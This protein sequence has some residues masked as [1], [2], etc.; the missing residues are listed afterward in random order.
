MPFMMLKKNCRVV[1]ATDENMV[2]AH[3]HT[4]TTCNT[5]FPLHECASMLCLNIKCL[6]CSQC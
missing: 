6:S 3:T 2:H 1:Q 5:A 4:L